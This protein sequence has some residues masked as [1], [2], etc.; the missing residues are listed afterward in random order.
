MWRYAVAS[1]VL[2]LSAMGAAVAIGGDGWLV[3]LYCVPL[4]GTAF[5]V[6]LTAAG[7][8]LVLGSRFRSVA[9]VQAFAL[10]LFCLL[11]SVFERPP[12]TLPD[13]LRLDGL[14]EKGLSISALGAGMCATVLAWHGLRAPQ[15]ASQAAAGLSLLVACAAI[16]GTLRAMGLPF[17]SPLTLDLLAASGLLYIFAEHRD[18]KGQTQGDQP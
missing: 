1:F 2:L 13:G 8:E 10:A 3:S 18:R 16:G 4:F 17:V 6:F 9:P 5:L 15:L 14:A 12:G 7:L 11:Y